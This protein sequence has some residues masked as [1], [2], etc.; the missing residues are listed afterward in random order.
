MWTSHSFF[1]NQNTFLKA[2]KRRLPFRSKVRCLRWW[3]DGGDQFFTFSHVLLL[4][5][6]IISMGLLICF[7]W[8]WLIARRRHVMNQFTKFQV[9]TSFDSYKRQILQWSRGKIWEMKYVWWQLKKKGES[10]YT[11]ILRCFGLS[12]FG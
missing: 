7:S 2:L 5:F 11:Q 1:S 8:K 4:W 12:H 9:H 6:L 3:G 10:I